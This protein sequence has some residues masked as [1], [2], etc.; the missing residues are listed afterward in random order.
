MTCDEIRELLELWAM[1]LLES[2]EQAAIGEHLAGGCEICNRNLGTAAGL[3]AA[4]LASAPQADASPNLRARVIGMVRPGGHSRWSPWLGAAAAVLAAALVWTAVDRGRINSELFAT[5]REL[6]ASESEAQR[7]NA[8]FSFL[9]DPQ[10]RPASAR[11]E[12]NQPHGTYF[13]SPKGV[14]LIASNLPA[15]AAGRTYQMWIIP[16]GQAPRPAGLFRPDATG[17]AI[18]FESAPVDVPS[19]EAL[20]ISVEP[21]V[22][23]TAPT[24]TP[25][26]VTPVAG[27]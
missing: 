6:V 2:E 14:L 18:H 13:I 20:A 26:L 27:L 11:P 5:R 10:T 4:I 22:G 1:G 17:S 24:T 16:K 12:A 3:N 7:L 15:L 8:A 9:R 23:S 21:E 25:Q 19:A